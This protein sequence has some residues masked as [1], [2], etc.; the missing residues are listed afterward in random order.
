MMFRKLCAAAVLAQACL[1]AQTPSEVMGKLVEGNS[2]FVSGQLQ[3]IPNIQQAKSR[4]LETQLPMAVILACA[5]ARVPPELIFDRSLGELFVVRVAGNIAGPL[6]TASVEYGVDKLK[7]PLVMVLGHENC[8]AVSA[9]ISK[10]REHLVELEPLYPYIDKALKGCPN[11]TVLHNAVECNVR[12][13]MEMLKKSSMIAPLV[14]QGKVKVVGA[15]F[16]F[17]TGKVT[18]LPD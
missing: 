11:P 13:N 7:A 16:N 8:G 15:Y 6:E 17:D 18:V 2:H 10:G 1:C 5:D 3:N 4:L 9:A 14:Q 12:Y